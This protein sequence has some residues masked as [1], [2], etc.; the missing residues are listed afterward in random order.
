MRK[1]NW[2]EKLSD[3]DIVWLRN[4]GHVSEEQIAAHQAQFDAEVP[5]P[6]VPEDL[7]TRSALDPTARA[8]TPA[9]TGD[10]PVQVDPTQAD[11]QDETEDDYDEWSAADLKNEVSARN[12]IEGTSE[13][14]VVGTGKN[15]ALTKSS[16]VKASALGLRGPGDPGSAMAPLEVQGRM[17]ARWATAAG[18]FSGPSIVVRY[19]GV[20]SE[21]G[22]VSQWLPKY[23]IDMVRRMNRRSRCRRSVYTDNSSSGA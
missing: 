12:A 4:A 8:H 22:G 5:D 19:D 13:V 10:G 17:R 6:E 9:E 23:E 1:L 2:D 14:E 15:G 11:P 20:A 3:E 7:V 21:F 18:L 16:Y